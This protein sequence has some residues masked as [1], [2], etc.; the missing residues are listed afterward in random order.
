[1]LYL[2]PRGWPQ[3]GS[4]F[5]IYLFALW[6]RICISSSPRS[7]S[8]PHS[9]CCGQLGREGSTLSCRHTQ[10]RAQSQTLHFFAYFP[11]LIL[12]QELNQVF[13]PPGPI[14]PFH[15]SSSGTS[16]L[17]Y[18]RFAPLLT[19]RKL[20]RWNRLN[21][22]VYRT[23]HFFLPPRVCLAC[24]FRCLS[25][26]LTC[27]KPILKK[28]TVLCRPILSC[29]RCGPVGHSIFSLFWSLTQIAH[30]TTKTMCSV[31]AVLTK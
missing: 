18:F 9:N 28:Q 3:R 4:R 31:R 25:F 8:P 30:K 20:P 13:R 16:S 5:A 1:M 2:S 26:C 6:F 21:Y 27:P 15:G 10:M 19:V 23:L 12:Q 17:T 22:V 29:V 14:C 24:V 11:L 7:C